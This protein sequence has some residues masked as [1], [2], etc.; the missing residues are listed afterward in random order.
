MQHP[1]CIVGVQTWLLTATPST[2]GMWSSGP[3]SK[4]ESFVLV[5][6]VLG[7]TLILLVGFRSSL[8]TLCICFMLQHY[9]IG[10]AIL[11]LRDVIAAVAA[12]LLA[13]CTFPWGS[14]ATDSS[15][16]TTPVFIPNALIH[17]RSDQVPGLSRQNPRINYPTLEFGTW[18]KGF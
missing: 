13:I 15:L 16:L 5:L 7:L 9:V 10:P 14:L 1:P 17:W 3:K 8:T 11:D 4:C 6:T 18:R 12:L 2:V